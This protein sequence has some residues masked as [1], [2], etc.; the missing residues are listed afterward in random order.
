MGK[1]SIWWEAPKIFLIARMSARS[2]GWNYFMP[3]VCIDY[4]AVNTS[5]GGQDT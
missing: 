3:G 4:R 1:N 2:A 5:A